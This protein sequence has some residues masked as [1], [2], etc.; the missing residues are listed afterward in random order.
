M[1]LLEEFSSWIPHLLAS[2]H[3][4]GSLGS[5]KL[6]ITSYHEDLSQA[7]WEQESL[8][9]QGQQV[10]LLHQS[11]KTEYYIMSSNHESDYP[12]ILIGPIHTQGERIKQ[13]RY[14]GGGNLWRHLRILPTTKLLLN[15]HVILLISVGSIIISLHLF[16]ILIICVFLSF[17]FLG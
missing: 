14:I 12:I 2:C 13:C 11:D 15:S 16:L 8:L 7:L 6:P 17:F 3:V 4:W 9:L 1:W 10:N 5:W